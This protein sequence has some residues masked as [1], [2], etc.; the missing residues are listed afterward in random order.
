MIRIRL[1]PATGVPVGGGAAE[2]RTFNSVCKTTFLVRCFR[3]S[4]RSSK[5]RAA[6]AP[7]LITGLVHGGQ[8]RMP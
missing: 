4:I 5:R 8:R 3:P 7:K 2:W 1:R 6:V